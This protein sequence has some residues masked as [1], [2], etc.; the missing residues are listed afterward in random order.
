MGLTAGI[1]NPPFQIVEIPVYQTIYI[2]VPLHIQ[3]VP[4]PGN[5]TLS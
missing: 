2:L 1:I 4:L 3:R 5:V